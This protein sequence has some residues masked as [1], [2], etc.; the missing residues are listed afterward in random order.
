[1]GGKFS[2][3]GF[4]VLGIILTVIAL[5]LVLMSRRRQESGQLHES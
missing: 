3:G 2:F 1:M 4:R 5:S